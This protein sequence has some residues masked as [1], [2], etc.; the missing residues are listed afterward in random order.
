MIG[1]DAGDQVEFGVMVM[2]GVAG[3][4]SPPLP[5][6]WVQTP[7]PFQSSEEDKGLGSGSSPEPPKKDEEAEE[8]KA[9]EP[10]G[11]EAVATPEFWGDLKSFLLQRIKDEAEGERLVDVFKGAWEQSK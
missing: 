1:K 5:G 2:G 7:P 6:T 11:K 9:P 10:T 8:E 4:V 3:H